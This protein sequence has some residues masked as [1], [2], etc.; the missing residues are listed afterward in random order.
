MGSELTMQPG[1]A[2]VDESLNIRNRYLMNYLA[3]SAMADSAR[4]GFTLENVF[5]TGESWV[6]SK[7]RLE[8]VAPVLYGNPLSIYTWHKGSEKC[9][10]FRDYQVNSGG[11]IAVNA[12]SVWVYT[13]IVRRKAI[14]APFVSDDVFGLEK[15]SS[16]GYDIHAWKPDTSFA[17]DFITGITIRHSDYDPLNHVNN[18]VYVD[19]IE[20]L[21][22]LAG[23][24]ATKK[25]AAVNIQYIRE[26]GKGVDTIEASLVALGNGRFCF[27]L[28]HGDKV[29]A[30]GEIEWISIS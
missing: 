9:Y 18:A 13:S 14:E 19:Y 15:R 5:K 10:G 30:A 17:P 2:E 4:A 27:N 24:S 20:T 28:R 7:I 26:I 16:T 21:W 25:M 29:H 6:L 11:E 8:F 1:I 12:T 3:E 22:H 23:H